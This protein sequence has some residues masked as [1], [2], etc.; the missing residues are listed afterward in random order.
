MKRPF[1]LFSLTVLMVISVGNPF[2]DLGAAEVWN[3]QKKRTITSEKRTIYNTPKNSRAGKGATTLFNRKDF[4]NINTGSNNL[5]QRIQ[6]YRQIDITQ[7][8]P[9]KLWGL[10]SPQALASKQA[11]VDHAL[12]NEYERKKETAKTVI[13]AM[14]EYEVHRLKAVRE[15]EKKVAKYHEDREQYKE[16]QKTL[17]EQ[18]F[19]QAQSS[20]DSNREKSSQ[21]SSE[22]AARSGDNA[23]VLK[24]PVRLFNSSKK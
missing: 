7:Q 4:G 16:E 11:D 5:N 8:Q 23:Q 17:K 9:S 12:K 20:S 10:L 3:S 15:H 6:S 2:T 24:G 22:T 18:A 19:A 13:A 21:K 1:L 14:K